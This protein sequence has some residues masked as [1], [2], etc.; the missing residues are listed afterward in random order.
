MCISRLSAIVFCAALCA[1][2]AFAASGRHVVVMVWDG[3]RPDF[4]TEHNAPT[5]YQLAQHGVTFAHHHSVYLSATEVNGTAISTG[6][7]PA[8]SGI[9]GNSEYRPD[10]DP[11][12]GVHTELPDVVRKGDGLTGGKYLRRA[13][14]AEIVRQA[15]GKACV[16]GAKPIALLPDRAPRA[17]ATQGANV[18]AGAT[19]PQTLLE[20][21]TNMY[22]A[23]PSRSTSRN[24]WTA[25]VMIE[26]VWAAG[27]PEFSFLWMN[28][29]DSTQ[30]QTGPGSTETLAAI[31]N[32]DQNLAR[33]L[34]ALEAKGVRETTDVLI[35][36]DHGCSTVTAHVDLAQELAKAGIKATRAFKNAPAAGE[37]LIVSN[38][39]TAF[40]Y[41]IG[42]E[43]KV[44]RDIVRFLQKWPH[45]GVIFSRQKLPG[46]FGLE[47]A[48]LDSEAPPDIAVSLRWNSD[49]NTNGTP[50]MLTIDG[51]AFNPGQG[52]HVSLSPH[53]LHATL[54]AAG[55]DF[56]SGIVD[57]LASG[58][59]DIAPTVLWI[60]NIKPPQP[61][62]GRVLSEALAKTGPAITSFE[63]RRLEA[64][65]GHG[66]RQY[67][68]STLVNGVEYF[69]EG[70][71]ADAEGSE[72]K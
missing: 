33:I 26:P 58:N 45:T 23:Y 20:S 66:W 12:K 70:N 50:G 64:S 48:H 6:C 36:S 35:V 24:D 69:D 25:K 2:E 16:A 27:V 21:I 56:R 37:V 67:L 19:L 15:G 41:V 60:L 3:M 71:G 17:S 46:T 13:T 72:G 31:R 30:H 55:P 14:L 43:E 11:L 7:Y 1:A 53:D 32:S 61:M 49:R 47:Q 18:F 4:V 54:V 65:D 51:S 22:G 42:H 29:P 57:T 40:I 5:L 34:K 39:G 38:S 9:V 44:A 28:E 59:I 8:H 68:S 63:P 10:I 62:D 52:A